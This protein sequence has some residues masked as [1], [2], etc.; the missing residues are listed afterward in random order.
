VAYIGAASGDNPAFRAY[1]G[2]LLMRAGAG[3]V[4]LAPLCGRRGDAGK[5]RAVIEGSPAVF[6][7]GGDVEEGMRVLE[8]HALADFLREQY[9][10]GKMFFG[11]SAGS[12][13]LAEAWVRWK[14]PGDEASGELFPCLGI[15]PVLC[16]THGED[17]GWEELRVLQ[18]LSRPGSVCYGIPSGAALVV[19]PGGPAEALGGEVHRFTRAGGTVVQVESLLPKGGG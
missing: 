15:A 4:K 5:A 13:M 17:E 9:R 11:I 19:R 16:D 7:S 8:K 6:L 18:G 1:I 10:A 3:E 14:D 2:R 12:I